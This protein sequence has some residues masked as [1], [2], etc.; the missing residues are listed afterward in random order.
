MEDSLQLYKEP[1]LLEINIHLTMPDRNRWK[2][3]RL[4]HWFLLWF[5]NILFIGFAIL[6][7]TTGETP[8]DKLMF[9]F[10]LGLAFVTDAMVIYSSNRR[11]RKAKKQGHYTENFQILI[12]ENLFS[13]QTLGHLNNES[14]SLR[15]E[16]FR[17]IIE[18]K[19]DFY[20]AF[21]KHLAYCIPKSQITPEQ[22]AFLQRFLSHKFG[23][24]FKSK[25]CK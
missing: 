12:S 23:N 4:T 14:V 21:N 22:C 16:A 20:L 10:F 11:V 15:W 6:A 2:A 9:V 5:A 13:F 25:C 19:Q 8:E 24:K 18:T 7:F 3:Y 17:R 1:T